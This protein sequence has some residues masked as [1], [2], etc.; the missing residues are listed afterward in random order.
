MQGM[1]IKING[2]VSVNNIYMGATPNPTVANGTRII[3]VSKLILPP[4]Q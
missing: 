4:P 1:K 3:A 2:E